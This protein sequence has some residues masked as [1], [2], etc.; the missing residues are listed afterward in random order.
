MWSVDSYKQTFSNSNQLYSSWTSLKNV[1]ST[2]YWG[3]TITSD[4][5][6]NTHIDN[7]RAKANKNPG[8]VKRNVRARRT[9]IKTK[10]Y[11]TLVRST[12]STAP[13]CVIH[14]LRGGGGYGSLNLSNAE[15]PDT[16]STYIIT[17]AAAQNY[18][19]SCGYNT[20]PISPTKTKTLSYSPHGRA[21]ISNQ[22]Q[23]I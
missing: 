13:V 11:E 12:L 1:K 17:P 7:I 19:R 16:V 15:Q 6:W 5:K 23:G 8:F 2:K 3:N 9:H 14:I 4:L 10:A 22:Y 20:S 21:T 18:K